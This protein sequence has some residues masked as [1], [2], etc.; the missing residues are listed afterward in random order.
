MRTTRRRANRWCNSSASWTPIS[1]AVAN[2]RPVASPLPWKRAPAVTWPQTWCRDW[3]TPSR[4]LQAATP[5][6]CRCPPR[7]TAVSAFSLLFLGGVGLLC[8]WRRV[9]RPENFLFR[10]VLRSC[11]FGVL[12]TDFAARFY[13]PC[14][15]INKVKLR[16]ARLVLGL[17]TFRYLSRPIRPIQPYHTSVVRCNEYWRWFRPSLGKK[18]QVLCNSKLCDRA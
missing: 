7:P 1:V 9:P 8:Y 14:C 18:R 15:H 17:V 4:R 12:V 16:R 11:C 6:H 10:K 3:A 2:R 5:H 13:N